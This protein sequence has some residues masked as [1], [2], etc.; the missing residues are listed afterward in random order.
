MARRERETAL[1]RAKVQGQ[2]RGA[3]ATEDAGAIGSRSWRSGAIVVAAVGL[4]VCGRVALEQQLEL[5]RADVAEQRDDPRA[6]VAH[7]G[8]AI[9]W[10]LP[11][12]GR[13]GPAARR[14]SALCEELHGEIDPTRRELAMS[15]D[16]TLRS[17]LLTA[18]SACAPD[19]AGMD[20]LPSVERRLALDLA[21]LELEGVEAAPRGSETPQSVDVADALEQGALPRSQRS[22]DAAVPFQDEQEAARWHLDRMQHRERAMGPSAVLASLAFIGFVAASIGLALKGFERS[23]TLRRPVG[24]RWLAA[25]VVLAGA[26]M[27]GLSCASP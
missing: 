6:Q 22:P 25:V 5:M 3:V 12:V 2:D 26:W 9:R 4:V 19:P 16:Y 10:R 7:L 27:I 13:Q 17:A 8:R 11:L 14:L 15:C 21:A 1:R 20:L 23:G 18:Q 24:A